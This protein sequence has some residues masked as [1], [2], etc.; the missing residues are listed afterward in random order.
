MDLVRWD[1]F[2][3]ME[4]FVDRYR[5][6]LGELP[7]RRRT[8]KEEITAC[9][10]A[11]AVDISESDAEYLIKAELPEISKNDVKVSVHEGVLSFQG[12]RKQEKEEKGKRFHRVERCYGSF[13]RS[14]TL[15]P[16][17]DERA[18]TAEFKDGVL[19]IHLPKS[20]KAKPAATEVPVK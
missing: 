9:D 17:V 2:R 13:E 8:S 1:P 18:V 14:F 3:E 12:E 6:L 16:N 19:N 20:A 5:R 11:P 7:A 10:W 15:P 4:N